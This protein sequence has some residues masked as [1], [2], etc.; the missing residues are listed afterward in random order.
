MKL[1]NKISF[2]FIGIIFLITPI[3]MYISYNSIRS[4][5][6]GAE[7]E[8][9]TDVNDV[10]AAQLMAGETPNKYTQGRPIVISTFTSPMPKEKVDTDE[11]CTYNEH[12]KRNECKLTV[13]SFYQINGQQYKISSYNYVTK[14]EQILSGM[15][16]AVAWKMLL[17]VLAIAITA[18]LLSAHIFAPFRQTMK[19]LHNFNLK[20]KER[21]QLP[22]ANTKEFEELNN[23]LKTMTDKA[24]DEYASVKE[25][26]ENASHELQT[27]LAIL[28]SKLDLLSETDINGTQASLI[29]DMQNAIEKLSRINRS[30]TLLTKLENHEFEASEQLKFCTV[31]KETI[32]TYNDMMALKGLAVSSQVDK[33][34]FIAMHP[35][36]AE[37]LF[38]NLLSNAIR[39]NI[40]G[41]AIEV[42]LTHEELCVRNTGLPPESPTEELFKRFKKSN[43]SADSI[44]LG[45]AIVKQICE[46]SSYPI[47]YTYADGWHQVSVQLLATIS[48]GTSAKSTSIATAEPAIAGNKQH[49][50]TVS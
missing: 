6:D 21:I 37:M 31:V 10:V 44:G 48:S 9:M 15:L 25:F 4:R 16:N 22:K 1:L 2:W 49:L 40:E 8:R 47:S 28:R 46:V 12:L 24:M 3:T 43:Q 39:H 19:V 41:G 11:L 29:G 50:L 35:T 23:F 20:Q 14:S 26:S 27:P 32:S 18:R 13:N 42:R 17:I 5:I 45:L 34:V 36:L 7:V 30:L 38:T 33:R